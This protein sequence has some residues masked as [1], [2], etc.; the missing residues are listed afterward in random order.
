MIQGCDA[1]PKIS[2]RKIITDEFFDRAQAAQ[3]LEADREMDRIHLISY[4][5]KHFLPITWRGE[6]TNAV[7]WGVCRRKKWQSLNVIPMSVGDQKR[8]FNRAR[9]KFGL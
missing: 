7:V 3:V 8:S 4:S 2:E 9:S 1:N 6:W 5:P